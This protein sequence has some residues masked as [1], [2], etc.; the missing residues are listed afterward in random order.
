[1]QHRNRI[2]AVHSDLIW[3]LLR[4]PV[5]I[6]VSE[7]LW[8]KKKYDTGHYRLL[9]SGPGCCLCV[10]NLSHSPLLLFVLFFFYCALSASLS[11]SV[12]FFFSPSSSLLSVSMLTLQPCQWASWHHGNQSHHSLSVCLCGYMRV[13]VCGWAGSRPCLVSK[14]W[15]EV[16]AVPIGL[17]L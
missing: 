10:V 2:T 15:G 1:M 3:L 6:C 8:V 13:C 17:M 16:A 14:S 7:G 9:T 4:W 12:L 5:S 11:P